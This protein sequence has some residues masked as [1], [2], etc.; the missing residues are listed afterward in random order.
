MTVTSTISA[1]QQ[2]VWAKKL[3]DDVMDDLFFST[4]GFIGTGEDAI[5]QKK[6]DLSKQAGDTIHFGLAGK[7]SGEGID[8]DDTLEGYEEALST[9]GYDLSIAQKRH[10]VR[11]KGIED[12]S[13]VGYDERSLAKQKLK[14]WM[15]EYLQDLFFETL[16]TSPT[17]NRKF[18]CS[19][20]HTSI[21]TLD[22]TDLLTSSYVSELKRKAKLASPKI[23]PIKHKGKDYYVLVVDP[24]VMRDLKA[25][26]SSPILTALNNAWWGGEDNPL[27]TGAEVVWDGVII[28]E[29]EGV[30]TAGDGASDIRIARNLLLGQQAGAWAIGKDIYWKEK[31]FDYDNQY[32]IATG[33]IHGFGKVAFNSEDY[34][35]IC[36]YSAAVA[37]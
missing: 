36:A 12:E 19:A 33:L 32:G 35:V 34:G 18:W 13:K 21:V 37:D 15:S 30:Y 6:N 1:L 5:I 17:D 10:A 29:H 9:Y 7:L 8:N 20:D 16:A 28:Y 3:Y 23:R 22:T 11:L 31:L 27:F 24:Y 26:T 25:E 2:E 4:R 14:V